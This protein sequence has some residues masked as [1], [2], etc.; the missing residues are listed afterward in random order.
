MVEE[1]K[2]SIKEKPQIYSKVILLYRFLIDLKN[3]L[4]YGTLEKKEYIIVHNKKLVYLNNSKVACSSIKKTFISDDVPDD[5]SIHTKAQDL[6]REYLTDGEK[7]YFKF[8]FVRN[9]FDRLVSCYES[10]YKKDK[11]MG[12]EYLHYDKYLLGYIKKDKG[13]EN[14]VKK[15]DKIPDFLADRHFQS[16]YN[17]THDKKGEP[18]V[19]Y[20][21]KYE[22]L[23]EDFEHFKHKYKLG[24]LP[25]FNKAVQ[26]NWMD[27]Y[28]VESAKIVREKYAKD[29]EEFGY[30]EEY[31]KLLEYLKNKQN[32]EVSK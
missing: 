23:A 3:V 25:H 20:I 29:I 4:S 26:R 13:F 22:N 2:R 9:P 19:D 27:Y 6:S 28:T 11:K 18:L 7:E 31:Q 8:T 1:L 15:V 14:F 24:D 16:Q 30:E 5:Y 12:Q 32:N 17:L 21:G 10:K